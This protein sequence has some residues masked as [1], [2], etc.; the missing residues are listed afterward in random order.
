MEFCNKFA[1]RFKAFRQQI[2]LSQAEFAEKF[3]LLHHTKI[4]RIESGKSYPD[5]EDLAILSK[6]IDVDLHW[7]I[8]G[9]DSPSV[10][11]INK[12]LKSYGV[13]YLHSLS[14][15]ITT[16]GVERE[17]LEHKADRTDEDNRKLAW[18][19]GQ[20]AE[21]NKKYSLALDELDGMFSIRTD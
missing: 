6:N 1:K 9:E 4:S 16:L 5:L 3:D 20:I 17:K 11:N 14:K 7:L 19:E 10:N 21:L 8:T 15:E 13:A 12:R 2:G 18:L